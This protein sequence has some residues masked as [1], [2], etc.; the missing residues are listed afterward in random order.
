M[1]KKLNPQTLE[2]VAATGCTGGCATELQIDN[3]LALPCKEWTNMES[4]ALRVRMLTDNELMRSGLVRMVDRSSLGNSLRIKKHGIDV[5]PIKTEA[6]GAAKV[7]SCDVHFDTITM[8]EF[9]KTFYV[10][11]TEKN[12]K[13]CIKSLIGTKWQNWVS[14]SISD[15]QADMFDSTD[16][17]DLII[18]D[19]VDKYARFLPKRILMATFNN[20]GE[21]LHG[22]DGILAKS[23]YAGKGQYF[24]TWKF[25]L[26]Q[27]DTDFNTTFIQAIV[28]G[29]KFEE[30]PSDSVNSEEYILKFVDWLNELKENREY[31]FDVSFDAANFEVIVAS[32]IATRKIDLKV[33][34][35][36]GTFVDW[37]CAQDIMLAPLEIEKSMMINDVPLLFQYENIDATNFWQKFKDYLKE[38]KRYLHRN[39]YEDISMADIKIGIDPELLLEWEDQ[40]KTKLIDCCD[41]TED[42]SSK[43]GLS[44]D[45]FVPLNSMNNTGLFFMTIQQNILLFSD[46]TNLTG[47]MT[48]FGRMRIKESNC[49]NKDGE[50][51][52]YGGAPPIG[53]DVEQWGAF[54]TNIA[55]SYFV[56]Q[57]NLDTTA[58][59][60]NTAT[61]LVCYDDNVKNNCL[62][63]SSCTISSFVE[64]EATY[65]VGDDETTVSVSVNSSVTDD[66][67]LTYA[68]GYTLGDGTSASGITTPNFLITLP[69]DQT[70]SGF[71]ISV[72]GS[73][74]A[75]IDA[76]DACSGIINYSERLGEGNGQSFCTHSNSY[77]QTGVQIQTDLVLQYEA[78]GDTIQ[79]P[80]TND[81]L[82]YAAPSDF[83]AIALEIEAILPGADVSITGVIDVNTDTVIVGVPSYIVNIVILDGVGEQTPAF[84]RDC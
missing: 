63:D 9:E 55:G 64:I 40:Y 60:K 46:G 83:D 56:T 62:V 33:V 42:I 20:A 80:L 29:A 44:I 8:E 23:Y 70:D 54:A 51:L 37:G 73:V 16:L 52:V 79:V 49:D 22:D 72:N 75:Q 34:L 50:V 65:S 48:N 47:G 78:V 35:N 32:T 66:A 5:G 31:L 41:P 57:N 18:A 36:D 27:V 13:I 61:N 69:G 67:T 26:T 1:A 58:P 43:I 71:V 11:N 7:N 12:L 30:L 28:G 15:Y 19:V 4:E 53:M 84:N 82:N 77:D 24:N 2:F 45:K 3:G 76:V 38:F 14:D 39:G 59:Y 6:S 25:D 21:D 74:T 17:A 68:L 81:L 10:V